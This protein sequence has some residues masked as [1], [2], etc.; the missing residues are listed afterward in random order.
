MKLIIDDEQEDKVVKLS[1]VHF[2]DAID[3][4][5]EHDGSRKRLITFYND[6]CVSRR[7][8]ADIGDFKFDDEGRLVIE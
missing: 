1:L 7:V 2:G 5:A 4:C 6:G 8:N 3:L